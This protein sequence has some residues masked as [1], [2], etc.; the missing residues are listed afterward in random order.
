M[1]EENIILDIANN[2]P[3]IEELST[4][5]FSVFSSEEIEKANKIK[6]EVGGKYES[7]R[8]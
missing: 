8:L 2:Y 5:L 1:G 6:E 4:N 7:R 3:K